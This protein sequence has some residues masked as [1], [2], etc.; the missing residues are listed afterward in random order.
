MDSSARDAKG[1]P[2]AFFYPRSSMQSIAL[3]AIRKKNAPYTYIGFFFHLG[4]STPNT[5]N[6]PWKC[7]V[8]AVAYTNTSPTMSQAYDSAVAATFQGTSS[9]T[10]MFRTFERSFVSSVWTKS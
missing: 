6:L 3:F 4:A 10:G 1:F 5:F 2:L 8:P 9:R 7:N